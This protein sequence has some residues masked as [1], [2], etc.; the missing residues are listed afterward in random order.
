[1]SH[2]PRTVP[3]R[4]G[5]PRDERPRALIEALSP[6]IRRSVTRRLRRRSG[7]CRSVEQEVDDMVQTVL[8]AVFAE[9][10]GALEAWDPARGVDLPAFVALV[11]AREVDSLLRSRRRNPWTE[12]PVLAEALDAAPVSRVDPETQAGSRR[13]LSTVAAHMR[14]RTSPL[15]FTIFEMLFLQGRE[16]QDIAAAVGLR[17][18]AVH[19]WKCRLSRA[20]R[21]IAAGLDASG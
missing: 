16:P 5:P 11:A 2:A 4:G 19:T 15:G 3:R 17:V 14:A 10:G 9:R 13:M 21:D 6:V 18:A 20:A 1:M 12:E 8:L 7:G